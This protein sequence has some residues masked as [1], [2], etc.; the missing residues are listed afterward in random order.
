MSSACR[1]AKRCNPISPTPASVPESIIP[2]PFIYRR[3]TP[4]SGF[5]K[6]AFPVTERVAGEIV[7]LPMF[8]QLRPEQQDTVAKKVLEFAS[9]RVV[10]SR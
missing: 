5:R 7:S 8:P 6:G 1:I 4:I 10:S 2:F 3:L 9:T